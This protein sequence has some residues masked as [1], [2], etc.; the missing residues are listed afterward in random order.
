MYVFQN[1][2]VVSF[3]KNLLARVTEITQIIKLFRNNTKNHFVVILLQK[4]ASTYN[5]KG[6]AKLCYAQLYQYA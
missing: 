6:R 5:N 2:F 3:V 1:K 4:Y